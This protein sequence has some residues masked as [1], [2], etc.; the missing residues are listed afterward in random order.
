ME[1]IYFSVFLRS[2]ILHWKKRKKILK[3]NKNIASSKIQEVQCH[4]QAILLHCNRLYML[5]DFIYYLFVGSR[6]V[7]SNYSHIYTNSFNYLPILLPMGTMYIFIRYLCSTV[8]VE[9]SNKC[10]LY[11]QRILEVWPWFI[12]IFKYLL[13]KMF[14]PPP[15]LII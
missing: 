8:N 3:L 12:P 7:Q 9:N 1:Q 5:Y 4:D 15:N 10:K 6:R 11:F 2:F 13:I 14:T